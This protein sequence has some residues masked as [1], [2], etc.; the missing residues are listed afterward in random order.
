MNYRTV[1]V[2][3][4]II[5]AGS[6]IAFA[7]KAVQY[8]T[9]SAERWVEKKHTLK[10]TVATD[11]VIAPGKTAALQTDILI[12]TDS[13][14]QEVTGFGGTFNELGWDAL[15]CLSTEERD[16]V[17]ASLFATDGISFALGRTPIGASDYAFGYYSYN[18]VKDDYTMR[19]FSIDRDRY[20][21]IPYIKEALKLRPDLKLWAS[22]WT[23]PAWMKV[24][25]HYSQKSNGIEN[26]DI[27]HNRLD[28]N[29]NMLGNVTGF[30]MEQGCLQAYALYFSKYVQEYRKNGVDIQMVM[31][32]NEIAWT[33]CW[34][35]CTWRPEDLAIFV[36]QY[37]G[38]QF[39]KDS[40]K[41]Q[42]WLGTVNYPNP[43]Y[44]RTFLNQRDVKRYVKGVG[45][46][47][48]GKQ[49][50]PTIQREYPQY[51][52]MQTENQ[53]GNAEN[54]W[55]SLEET[56]KSVVHCFNSG[57]N[58]YIYWN[59]VLDET[60]KSAWDWPQNSLIIVNRSMRKVSYTDEY[61]LMKHLSR[62]VQPGSR[63]LKLSDNKNALAFR[64]QDNKVVLVVYNPV[65]QSQEYSFQIEDK[66]LKVTLKAESINTFVF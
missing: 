31:P 59:M 55:K 42:I 62:F 5:C 52:Y 54:N 15:Q 56:W 48:S 47:W 53:C 21:L 20:I 7:Q 65:N 32:Q 28:P 9:T 44:M 41:T 3:C 66:I 6:D 18:D 11:K 17:M 24:N 36:T 1:I 58:S 35:S 51:R 30:K 37:L 16:R 25:E 27:G 22:P 26:T 40:L 63:L 43:N 12:Y 13:L 10:K 57:V 14:L 34:P 49:A 38:P 61:Y 8:S 45:V 4:A 19:N 33:P 29:R 50:L 2:V 39:E 46:Q 64:T 23:P 60:G